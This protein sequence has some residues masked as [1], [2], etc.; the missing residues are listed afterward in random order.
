MPRGWGAPV[1]ELS[2]DV[3]WYEHMQAW[4]QEKVDRM[5]QVPLVSQMRTCLCW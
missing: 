2:E 1:R 5:G 4:A 3:F